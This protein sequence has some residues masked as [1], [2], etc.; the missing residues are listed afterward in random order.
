MITYGRENSS[1]EAS[2]SKFEVFFYR[3][4]INE[5]ICRLVVKFGIII[6]MLHFALNF[7]NKIEFSLFCFLNQNDSL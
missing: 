5:V 6:F 7:C 2:I 4:S 1:V 3:Q